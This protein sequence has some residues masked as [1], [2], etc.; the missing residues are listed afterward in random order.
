MIHITIVP[1]TIQSLYI[2]TQLISIQK[3]FNYRLII[4]LQIPVAIQFII[5]FVILVDFYYL[6]EKC[7]TRLKIKLKCLVSAMSI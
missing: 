4:H 2:M 5:S 3:I 6:P 7:R 1:K